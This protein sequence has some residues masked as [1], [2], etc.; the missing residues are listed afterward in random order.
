VHLCQHYFTEQMAQHK[1][2]T[3][4]SCTARDQFYSDIYNFLLNNY[5]Q[6]LQQ[7][8]FDK[9]ETLGEVEVLSPH[10]QQK[11]VQ[12]LLNSYSQETPQERIS[13]IVE[14]Y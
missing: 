4:L 13:R 5:R 9:K 2:F 14:E 3:G 12:A 8:A 11:N 1:S 10:A 7:L 6:A